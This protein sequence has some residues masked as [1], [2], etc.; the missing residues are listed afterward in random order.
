MNLVVL[1]GRLTDEPKV[2]QSQSGSKIVKYTLAVDRYS[3]D[4][5]KREADFI[6]C[7][8]F[9]GTADF[10]EKY[11]HKGTKIA[12]NGSI[13]TGSYEKDGKKVYTTDVWVTSHEFCESRSASQAQQAPTQPT[14]DRPPVE[15]FNNVPE[16]N[17][18]ELPF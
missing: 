5:D 8:T 4:K 9:G 2:Y 7:I 18:E 13:K 1:M 3:K 12:V 14:A 15:T 17:V 11:L 10:A 16:G 6:N